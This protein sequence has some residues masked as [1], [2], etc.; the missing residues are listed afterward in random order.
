MHLDMKVIKD[1]LM[2]QV[3]GEMDMLVADQLRR[4]IDRVIGSRRIN[5]LIM[6]LNSVTF[7]DSAGIGVILGRYKKISA[8]GGRMYIIRPRPAV[9][10]ILELAGVNKLVTICQDERDIINL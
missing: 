6:D 9:Q 2:V 1:T 5:S 10:K 8:A 4:E 3:D 7:I